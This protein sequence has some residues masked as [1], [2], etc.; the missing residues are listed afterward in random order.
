MASKDSQM[1]TVPAILAEENK[2]KLLIKA[3]EGEL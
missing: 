1:E 2:R 3:G